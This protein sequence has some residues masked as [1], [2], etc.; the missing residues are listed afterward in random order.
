MLRLTTEAAGSPLAALAPGALWT[1]VSDHLSTIVLAVVGG[2]ILVWLALVAM[3][4]MLRPTDLNPTEALRLLPDTLVLIRRLA[5]DHNLP[6]GVR[7][8]LHLL[9]AYLI[10]PIDLIPDF[11][12]V[13]GYA[14]DAIIVA[15]ALRS[16]MRR[17]GPQALESHWPGSAAGL[18][19]IRYLAGIRPEPDA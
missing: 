19:T 9:L 18:E 8:R 16:V 13:I 17:S 11:L 12:P 15:V 3:L 6:R 10:V 5:V 4:I 1:Q 14:D 2:V 7:I